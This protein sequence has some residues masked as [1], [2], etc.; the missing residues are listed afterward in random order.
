MHQDH[1][2]DNKSGENMREKI[3]IK[4]NSIIRHRDE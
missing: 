4:K 2:K 3:K 1:Q